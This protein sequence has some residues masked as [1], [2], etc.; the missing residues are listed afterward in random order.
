MLT[1]PEAPRV[2]PVCGGRLRPKEREVLTPREKEVGVLLIQGL[3][4]KEIARELG[5]TTSTVKTHVAN[6]LQHLGVTNRTQA[7][8]VL[9]S[10]TPR[11]ES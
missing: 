4:D 8:V 11:K 10:Q 2:C 1:H 3:G 6:I 7:A 5:I 9:L